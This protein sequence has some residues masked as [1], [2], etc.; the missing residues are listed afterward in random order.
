[1]SD[2]AFYTPVQIETVTD[3]NTGQEVTVSKEGCKKDI[4]LSVYYFSG[5][6]SQRV[7]YSG[8]KKRITSSRLGR[9]GRT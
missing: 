2:E 9:S 7:Q 6:N 1:M 8:S 4:K 5:P 3:P